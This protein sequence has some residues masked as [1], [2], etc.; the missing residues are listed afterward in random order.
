LWAGKLSIT[1]ENNLILSGRELKADIL[2]QADPRDDYLSLDWIKTISPKKIIIQKLY[3]SKI[4]PE[5]ILYCRE[6]N[7]EIIDLQKAGGTTLTFHSDRI[8]IQS[9]NKEHERYDDENRK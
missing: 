5:T 6:N 4:N 7:I 9:E 3:R 2:I 8:Q 1:H